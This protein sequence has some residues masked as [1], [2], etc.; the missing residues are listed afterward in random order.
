MHNRL[1]MKQD[2]IGFYFSHWKNFLQRHVHFYLSQTRA[3]FNRKSTK[4]KIYIN[5]QGE[6]VSMLQPKGRSGSKYKNFSRYGLL[7]LILL[8]RHQWIKSWLIINVHEYDSPHTNSPISSKPHSL[9]ISFTSPSLLINPWRTGNEIE[10][11]LNPECPA[12]RLGT[13]SRCTVKFFKKEYVNYLFF[14]CILTG[15]CWKE[16]ITQQPILL[17]LVE[18]EKDLVVK[19]I[20]ANG[21]VMWFYVTFTKYSFSFMR[22]SN[23]IV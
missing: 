11:S 3:I 10:V 15:D 1:V 17:L 2:C 16:G 6:K 18:L 13:D 8:P 5:C 22:L 12:K 21:S 20:E 9:G 14:S 4:L 23:S 7:G 19:K